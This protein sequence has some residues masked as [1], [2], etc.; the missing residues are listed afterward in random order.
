M[1]RWHISIPVDP[2][3]GS[4]RGGRG[5]SGKGSHRFIGDEVV[6]VNAKNRTESP[7]VNSGDS[8][9][10]LGGPCPPSFWLA[11]PQFFLFPVRICL[12][13]IHTQ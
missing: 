13:D 3:A 7:T 2:A 4:Q 12:V 6:P 5:L 10:G 8:K 9:G 11:P 1:A